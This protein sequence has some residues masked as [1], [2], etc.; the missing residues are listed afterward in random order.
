MDS[1]ILENILSTSR[2][3]E[4]TVRTALARLNIKADDVYKTV[5]VIS[6][7]ERVKV[8]LIKLL[9]SNSQVLILDE[10]T[11]FLDVHSIEALEH[12]L[13]SYPGLLILVS[14]DKRFRESTTS[15]SYN[16][17]NQT[18]VNPNDAAPRSHA[19][20]EMMVLENKITRVLSQ[21][22]EES[23]PELEAEFERLI[24]EKNEMKRQLE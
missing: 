22:S 23:T 20:D 1:S 17:Q 3:D 6:G 10:P 13:K 16:I 8:Q 2:Y 12:M 5:S 9:M 14:H 24:K 18:L 11:N 7:G 4:T 19:A 15:V 21:L